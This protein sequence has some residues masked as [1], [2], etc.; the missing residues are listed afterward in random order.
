MTN[1]LNRPAPEVTEVTESRI[2]CDG[3]LSVRPNASLYE[4][5]GALGHPRVY[6]TI[7]AAGFVDCTYCD[8][9]F[10]LKAGAESH[11]H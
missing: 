9:R 10:Q 1:A 5:R 4:G 11:G 3:G 6:L 7:G 2:A 8:R